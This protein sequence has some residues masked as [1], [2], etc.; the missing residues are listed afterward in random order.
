MS[1]TDTSQAD[2]GALTG[3]TLA[4][5]K[6]STVNPQF[7]SLRVSALDGLTA[8]S[9]GGQ[10]SALPLTAA[11]SRVTTVAAAGDS[12]LLPPSQV[13]LQ[14]WVINASANPMQVFG[15]GTD[16]INSVA[17]A[18]GVSQSAG[19]IATYYCTTLGNW[20]LDIG[21]PENTT[22]VALTTNGAIDPHQTQNYIITKAGVLADT[23]AAPTATV[24]DGVTITIT[25]NT[26]F[27]H[28]VTATGLF[29]TGGTAVN[30]ATFAAHPGASFTIQAYQGLWNILAANAVT[31]S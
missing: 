26:A 27:A 14:V 19:A 15:A 17:T 12:V 5:V 22:L 30:V 21:N 11:I 13:G 10:T 7:N 16:T 20:T 3:A 6:A 31:F 29:Q 18:T 24:D 8:H 25:S 9:G 2:G 1:L 23:L 4:Q 28:T